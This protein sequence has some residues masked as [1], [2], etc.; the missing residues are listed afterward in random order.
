MTSLA[1]NHDRALFPAS[2]RQCFHDRLAG[3]VRQIRDASEGLTPRESQLLSDVTRR[4]YAGFRT[5]ADIADIARFRCK[6]PGKASALAEAI[7][8]HT[9]AG[10]P[11]LVLPFF[12]VL[13]YEGSA[14]AMADEALV[15]HILS[16]SRSTRE[17][18]VETHVAQ[19]IASR[20][21]ADLMY[22]GR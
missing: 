14:N 19:A 17:R 4:E 11:G 21:V 9:L 12:D 13:R 10:H 15:E 5:V 20:R 16:P 2:E 1:I 8:G 18:M 7:R 3:A 22:T 6:D